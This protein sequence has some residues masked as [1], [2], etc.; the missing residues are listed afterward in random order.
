M[1]MN[2]LS[3]RNDR[4]LY[5]RPADSTARAFG[6]DKEKSSIIKSVSF[7]AMLE[8]ALKAE[9]CKDKRTI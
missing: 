6:L 7:S 8:N 5:V 9:I 1:N 3:L 2:L 4:N